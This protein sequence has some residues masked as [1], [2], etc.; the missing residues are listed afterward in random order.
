MR[1]L[2]T[3]LIVAAWLGVMLGALLYTIF[4]MA[5]ASA[6]IKVCVIAMLIFVTNPVGAHAIVK[7]AY[8]HGI[9]PDKPME[10]DDFR[11]DFDE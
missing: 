6:A 5:S 2:K 8:R 3:L 1:S 9:R 7:G 10:V 4:V 11:R